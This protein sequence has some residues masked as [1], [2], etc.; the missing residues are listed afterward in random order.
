M[1]FKYNETNALKRTV[2]VVQCFDLA[3]L[4]TVK[5]SIRSLSF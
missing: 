2:Y 5:T 4:L 3:P 1:H